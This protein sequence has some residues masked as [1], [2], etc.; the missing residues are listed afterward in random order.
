MNGELV[1]VWQLSRHGVPEFHYDPDW[2][3]SPHARPLS[4]SLPILPENPPHRGEYVAAWFENLL[5]ESSLIRER[6]RRRFHTS[7]TNAFD[8]LAS[9][10][11][12]CVG[13]V[14]ILPA[15][16]DPADVRRISGEIIS[17]EDLARVVREATSAPAMGLDRQSEDFRIA[18][19]GEQEKTALLRIGG[20]WYKPRGGTPTTHILKLPLG[21]VGSLRA[22]MRSSVE[23]EWLCMHFLREL[24]LPVPATEM[25]CFRDDVSEEKVL[26]VERFDRQRVSGAGGDWILRLPQEDLCQA[27]GTAANCKYESDGGPGIAECLT[28]LQA[29]DVPEDDSIVFALAQLAFWLLAAPDGHAKNFSIFLRRDGYGLT[30]LYDVVSA[31]PIIGHGPNLW[32]E[33]NVTLAMALRGRNPHRRM[34]RIAIRHWQM[35]AARTGVRGAFER[36]VELVKDADRA[37]SAVEADLPAGY[38]ERVWTAISGGVRRQREAFLAAADVD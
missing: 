10:G 13:A 30:P 7:S 19:A 21:F 12:D 32:A 9:I 22:D 3:R 29:G 27:T 28:V 4:L 17:E 5:P 33:Q 24:G 31:W 11:R 6:V 35:L 18:I 37:M 25:A 2:L 38:P 20:E 1:G 26:I 23:N 16:A 15:G 36:M 34:S 8:L 14:Q